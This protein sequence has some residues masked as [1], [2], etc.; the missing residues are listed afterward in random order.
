MNQC[1]AAAERIKLGPRCLAFESRLGQLVYALGKEIKRDCLIW[2]TCHCEQVAQFA[3][4]AHLTEPPPLFAHRAHTTPRK[5][6]NV[7]LVLALEKKK[8]AKKTISQRRAF[9]ASAIH[10]FRLILKRDFFRKK[11]CELRSILLIAFLE[12]RMG[13]Q[14]LLVRS[15]IFG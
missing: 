3:V 11:I 2:A 6:K 8:T 7:Y 13:A 14:I 5:C 9:R 1:G 4:N 10:H 15:I 12:V